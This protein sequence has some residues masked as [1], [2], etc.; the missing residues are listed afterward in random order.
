M[1][2]PYAQDDEEESPYTKAGVGTDSTADDPNAGLAV[3]T[4]PPA[5]SQTAKPYQ[6]PAQPATET[7]ATKAGS[8]DDAEPPK[9]FAQQEAQGVARPPAPDPQAGDAGQMVVPGGDPVTSGLAVG[10]PAVTMRSGAPESSVPVTQLLTGQTPPSTMPVGGYPK[11]TPPPDPQVGDAGGPVLPGGDPSGSTGPRGRGT[12]GPYTPDAEQLPGGTMGSG[13]DITAYTAPS[14]SQLGQV[15]MGLPDYGPPS[16]QLPAGPPKG[17]QGRGTGGAYTPDFDQLPVDDPSGS[18]GSGGD[19]TLTGP[20]PY[21]PAIQGG[22]G[23]GDGGDH[24]PGVPSGKPGDQLLPTPPAAPSS[25]DS[26]LPLLTGGAT[27]T[28]STPLQDATTKAT[29]D[30]FNTPNPFNSDEV[31]REY[32]DL[33][34][35]IDADYDT[36]Q[37]NLSNQ[38]AQRGLFGSVGKDFASGRAADTEVG[39]RTAKT[40]LA[41]D[42]AKAQA[43]SQGQYQANA[44]NQGQAGTQ[45]GQ[46]NQLA[47][48]N[49]L[50]GYGNDAFNHDLSTANFQENQNENEQDYLLRLLQ[51]GYGV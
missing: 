15:E 43:V 37:R 49:A 24:R 44:I 41:S 18:M 7:P 32:G 21:D 13:G 46:G 40:Q 23:G 35:G 29:L 31:K 11:L 33:G 28:A 5:S 9:T 1:I 25:A 48:L 47:W 39:R 26:I 30:Q 17:P 6:P 42:L 38:F 20:A 50:M 3:N 51:A 45:Q 36:R 10:E 19:S 4:G 22:L 12:A 27:G 34:A 8:P 2:K 14:P 16:G